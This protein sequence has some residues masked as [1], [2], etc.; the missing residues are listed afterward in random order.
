MKR[1]V[2]IHQKVNV[3]YRDAALFVCLGLA[4]QNSTC[5]ETVI[6]VLIYTS[7]QSQS[8]SSALHDMPD[9]CLWTSSSRC[10]RKIQSRRICSHQQR[11]RVNTDT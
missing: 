7:F 6:L 5:S 10:L 11:A 2:L 8:L 1:D 4:F 3:I 9:D